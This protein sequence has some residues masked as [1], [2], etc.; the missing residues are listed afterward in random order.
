M[1]TRLTLTGNSC[2]RGN[3]AGDHSMSGV[4]RGAV[5]AGTVGWISP[6][7]LQKTLPRQGKTCMVNARLREPQTSGL[8]EGGRA[9]TVAALSDANATKLGSV[10]TTSTE[11]IGTMPPAVSP[12]PHQGNTGRTG[13]LTTSHLMK[14]VNTGSPKRAVLNRPAWRRSRHISQTPRVMPWTAATMRTDVTE[15]DRAT[16]RGKSIIRVKGGAFVNE[17]P[18]STKER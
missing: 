18:I 3:P 9:T 17:A 16:D 2:N 1:P 6:S 12:N 5:Q 15:I 11:S 8:E 14:C 7:H 10:A 13:H 4:R